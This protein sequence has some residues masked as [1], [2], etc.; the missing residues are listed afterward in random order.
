MRLPADPENWTLGHAE[1]A[2][3]LAL[4]AFERYE[5]RVNFD[6][7]RSAQDELYRPYRLAREQAREVARATGVRSAIASAEALP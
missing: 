1:R 3:A 6:A 5:K 2:L 7:P 4:R